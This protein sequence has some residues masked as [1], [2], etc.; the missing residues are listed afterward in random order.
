MAQDVI[1]N[2]APKSTKPDAGGANTRNFPVL[3]TVKD[4]IDPTRSGRLKVFIADDP[5]SQDS[6]NS[7]SWITVNYMS[8]FFGKVIPQA[9]DEG[10][11]DYKANPSSY[12]MWNAPPDIGS[13]V[14]CI[15]V[16]GDSNYGFWIGCVP[17]PES[18]YMVP[19]I[20]ASDKIIA[21]GGEAESYGGAVRLP[22]T[23][24]NTNN[25]EVSDSPEFIEAPRPIHSYSASIMNQQG[26]IRD[27]VRGPIGSSAQR[28]TPSRVGWGVSTPGRPIY[29]GGY[30]DETVA[31]NL[32]P[33]KGEQLKV[34][35]RRGGH[36]IV[37]DDG[38]IIGRDQL[39]RIRTALG[40][41]I[42]M[43][44]DGQ[45]LMLLHS[46]GQSYIE[47]GK[48]GTVD[49]YSTNSINMR[50]QGDFNIH[51]D[52]NINIH[53]MEN[54]NIQAKNMHVNTEEELKLRSAKDIK[55]H[56]LTNFTVKAG[57]AFAAAAGGDASM[58]AGGSAYINGAKVNLNSGSASTQPQEIDIIPIIAQTDT[59]YD[60]KKGFMAAPGKLL[61][62]ASRAPAHA[63]WANAGQGV[64]IKTDLNASSQLPASPAPAA[65]AATSAGGNV[66]PPPVSLATAASAPTTPPISGALDQNTTGAVLGTVATAAAAG[67][68]AAAVNAGAAVVQTSQGAV[69]A[70]GAFAQ[71]ATQM[72]SSG[73]LKPGSDTLISGLVQSGANIAQAMPS[74]LFCGA[75]GAQD[76]TNFVKDVGA[77]ATSMVTN[78]QQAQ[79]ALTAVGAITGKEAPAQVAGLVTAA[80]TTG[81]GPTVQAIGQ[82]AGT[83]VNN[84]VGAVTGVA[85]SLQSSLTAAGANVTGAAGAVGAALSAIGAGSAAANLATTVTGGLGGIAGALKAM[86]SVP[87]LSG[88]LDQ[89]KG[90]AGSAFEAIKKSFKPLEAGVP[91]NLTAI[92]QKAAADGAAVAEQVTQT[93]TSLLNGTGNLSATLSGVA[94]G[95]AS[96]SSAIGSVNNVLGAVNNSI[97]GITGAVTS[98]TNTLGAITNTANAVATTVGGITALTGSQ[99]NP[100]ASITNVGSAITTAVNTVTA[101][102]GAASALSTGGT[103]ALAQVASVVQKG[104]AAATSS[105]LASGLSNLPGGVNTV[106]AVVNNAVGAINAL[107]GAEKVSGL[108][109][110]AQAAV[111]N[112]LPMP[113]IPSGLNSLASLAS[114]GLPAGAAAQ[115]QS[116]I[117]ALSSGTGGAIKLPTIGFNTTDRASITSQITSVLGDPKIP[118]PNLVGEISQAVKDAADQILADAE[119]T[120]EIIDQLDEFTQK[121]EDAEEAFFTAEAEL[122]AG[123]PE[124]DRLRDAW[125]AL[126]DDPERQSLLDQLN[127]LKGTGDVAAATG[128]SVA[129]AVDAAL[130]IASSDAITD[131]ITSGTSVANDLLSTATNSLKGISSGITAAS[132]LAGITTSLVSTA[133]TALGSVTGQGATAL[134]AL[135]KSASV[136]PSEQDINNSIAGLIGNVSGPGLG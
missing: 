100:A 56:A 133:T 61:T 32:E 7:D 118:V 89:A 112:G 72:V 93:G 113:Q 79:T 106:A 73:V 68:G 70:V 74:A 13:T 129:G 30:N 47:L 51:A 2:S 80:A 60:E 130:A 64:D 52:N 90:V 105:A 4:N 3:A 116:A 55:A 46:N 107:P 14:I 21:N 34:V 135:Q 108:I 95:I 22:V 91:Q 102:S 54:I 134:T 20:A 117:S 28:E 15:F 99:N 87:S 76:L 18:L 92:A 38:D 33:S 101:A 122:P 125:F 1:T 49:I 27:P 5:A 85:N 39:I 110:D 6:E 44:D 50:T 77:Q 121:I 88:L 8:S 119:K 16:N 37:M 65:A 57:A 126:L 48:E 132:N 120:F 12:G 9:G 98:V 86:G 45:T 42:L 35:A 78:L 114:A 43:S 31:S 59:L 10:Y 41:Q 131:L 29:E 124:I 66:A 82:A 127:D 83:S 81:I 67:P 17:D 69:A 71:S 25:A 24:I 36:S 62:I 84:V 115:L 94:S 96:V 136:A 75:P 26:I 103:S 19:A 63:P 97:P 58:A 23:N 11:G 128:A 53:A 109:K 111:M 40:H 104:A 123:D